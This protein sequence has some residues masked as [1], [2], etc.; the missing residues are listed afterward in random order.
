VAGSQLK[1]GKDLT[2]N[3]AQDINLTSAADTNKLTGSNSS[4]GGSIGIGITAGPNGAGITV[5]ASVNAARGSEKGN[6]TS[7]NET[8]LDA[9]QNVNLTSGRDTVLKGAQVNGDKVTADVGRDLTISSLQDSDKYNSKQQSMNAGASYT[10]GAGSGSGSF[11]ISRD[12]MKSNYDSVQEQTGIFAGKGGFDINVGNHTQ[13][14]G[15]VIASRA[16]AD[17][18]RLE[19]G[20]LGFTDINNKAEYKVEHQGVGFSSGAG[21]A[22]NLVSNMASTMLA[23]MGGSGHAEGTTQSAVADGAIIVRDQANQKQDVS[24][25]SRD[26]DHANGSIDPIF[27]KE[28]EQKRL[29]TA[30]MIGE[31]GNQVADIARTNG[32]IAATEAA[33]E[34]MKTAGS[35]ARNAAISQLKKTVKRLP[36]RRFMTRCTRPSITKRLTSLAWE[37]G[38]APSAPSRQQR[39]PFRR[40][41]VAILKLRL[42]AV[43][44]R[45]SPMPSRMPSRRRILRDACWPMRLSTPHLQPLPAEMRRRPQ[46]VRRWV[47]W[48]VRLRLTVLANRSAN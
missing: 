6:G 2:L 28:K 30:Q 39:R 10:W 4:K 37:R 7:W 1:A 20:T 31:I 42:R 45:I 17:K 8:T 34:K 14:D 9:G 13:L 5:S 15:A 35:D 43:P 16:D 44:R 32:K 46:P 12:K 26:T 33:N 36:I 41:Q 11:S 18:N 25:L 48:L 3:A 21:V 22:G 27:N 47:S 40:W 38:R 23:G 19:T 29:Q 24:T